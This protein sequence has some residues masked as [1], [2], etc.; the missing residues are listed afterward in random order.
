LSSWSALLLGGLQ[1]Q[2]REAGAQVNTE[3]GFHI[4]E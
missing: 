4:H 3:L 2:Q 1:Q